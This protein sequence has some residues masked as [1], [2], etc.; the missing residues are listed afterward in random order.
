MG[1]NIDQMS[2]DELAVLVAEASGRGVDTLTVYGPLWRPQAAREPET[3]AEHHSPFNLGRLVVAGAVDSLSAIGGRL[4]F[5]RVELIGHILRGEFLAY[6]RR[7]RFPVGLTIRQCGLG[8]RFVESL[9]S[10]GLLRELHLDRS[11]VDA[12]TVDALGKLRNLACLTIEDTPLGDGGV[13]AVAGCPFEALILRTVGCT[14]RGAAAIARAGGRLTSLAL[15]SDAIGDRGALEVAKLHGL[16]HLTLTGAAVGDRGSEAIAQMPPLDWLDLRDNLIGRP[17]MEALLDAWEARRSAPRT[18]ML[19]GNPGVAEDLPPEI[20]ATSDAQA[21]LAA[22]RR[23]RSAP[24]NRRPLNEAKLIVVGNEAVGKTSL[25]RFLTTGAPRDPDEKKTPGAAIH[26]RIETTT[27]DPSG[28]DVT[29]NVWDFGGQEIMHGTHRFFLTKRSL[30]VLLLEARR[31]DSGR[32]IFDWLKTIRNHGGDSPVLVVVNKCDDGRDNLGLDETAVTRD[33]PNVVGFVRTAC[34]DDDRSR[35]MIA[36]LR[37]RIVA[38]LRDD[39]RLKHVRD[40]MPR[41][42]L[43]IKDALAEAARREKVLD[44]A[45]FTAI[46]AEAPG[47]DAV[48]DAAERRFVM[49]LLHDLGVIVAHGWDRDERADVSTVTLLDPNWLTGAI[50]ALLNS[51]RVRDQQGEFGRD[52]LPALLG[53]ATAYP[54]KWHGYIIDM[55]QHEDIGLCF[56]IPDGGGRLLIPEALPASEPHYAGFLRDDDLL[57]CYDYAFLPPHLLPRFIVRAHRLLTRDATRWRTGVVLTTAGCTVLVRGNHDTRRVHLRVCG[58]PERQRAALEVVRNELE[59]VHALNPESNAEARVPL[60]DDAEVTVGYEHLLMLEREEGSAHAFRPER[61]KR[62]YTVGELLDG[63]RGRGWGEV[64]P[65]VSVSAPVEAAPAPAARPAF[66]WASVGLGLAAAVVTV[67]VMTLPSPYGLS[68]AVVAGVAA[69]A[70]A[71]RAWFAPANYHRRMLGAL[72][73][74]LFATLIGGAT[75]NAVAPT[76]GVDL[77]VDTAPHPIAIIVL[78]LLIAAFLY[79]DHVQRRPP[80]P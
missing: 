67:L 38:V 24:E 5:H 36:A 78:G 46:C 60:P 13:A 25:I 21:I 12:G 44:G 57:F 61:A 54:A 76:L 8:A 56:P 58:P 18:L 79:V 52:E 32:T 30:Y 63:V 2:R 68:V 73:G 75:I 70:V 43:R 39:P 16:T 50:Y 34:N 51:P 20:F 65:P 27:W 31:E 19:G 35:E 66:P 10:F 53:D 11:I 45:R 59:A 22:W 29:L 37:R 69:G 72:I 7:D 49:G 48:V 71:L 42:W 77:R 74:T 3:V 55:M 26:E 4:P 6:A 40:P 64:R 15:R 9:S 33:Y 62:R 17:G 41:A 1:P 23:Y 14:E 47:E 80:P 28:S